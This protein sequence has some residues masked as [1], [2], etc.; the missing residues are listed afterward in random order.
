[1]RLGLLLHRRHAVEPGLTS[2]CLDGRP[3]AYTEELRT[4]RTV[5]LRSSPNIIS[6]AHAHCSYGHFFGL[7]GARPHACSRRLRW[8]QIHIGHRADSRVPGAWQ[9]LTAVVAMTHRLHMLRPPT[10]AGN[11]G[12]YR[13]YLRREQGLSCLLRSKVR[14]S[15]SFERPYSPRGRRGHMR[16]LPV[17]R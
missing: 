15:I 11:S 6:P 14:L 3:E 17:M 10:T 4:V 9:C 7:D 1:M 2:V 13:H 16:V 5:R 12:S 8:S